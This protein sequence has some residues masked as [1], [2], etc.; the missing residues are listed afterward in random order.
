M[1]ICVSQNYPLFVNVFPSMV[2]TT[3][4]RMCARWDR[5]N[6]VNISVST[7][8]PAIPRSLS[9]KP[10]SITEGGPIQF[11]TQNLRIAT[12]D[13][14]FCQRSQPNRQGQMPNDQSAS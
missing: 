8:C 1:S 12:Q 11:P 7:S 14:L 3:R 13:F 4:T 10:Q 9:I 5:L 2:Y 6:S